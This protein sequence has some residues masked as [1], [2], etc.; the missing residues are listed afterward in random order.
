MV[1]DGA[2]VVVVVVVVVVVEEEVED[3]DDVIA[4]GTGA[5]KLGVVVSEVVLA[6]YIAVVVFVCAVVDEVCGASIALDAADVSGRRDIACP[7]GV[8]Y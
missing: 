7:D 5:A 3:D 1:V 2:A 8:I 6:L 4:G